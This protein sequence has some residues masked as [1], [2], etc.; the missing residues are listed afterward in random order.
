MPETGEIVGSKTAVLVTGGA[1]FIGSHLVDQLLS[2]GARVRV[3]DDLT[4]GH[5]DNLAAHLSERFNVPWE[6]FDHPTGL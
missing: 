3:V 4:S 6:F 1:S 5:R 2:R